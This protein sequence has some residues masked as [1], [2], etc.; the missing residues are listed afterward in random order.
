MAHSMT[1]VAAAAT[2]EAVTKYRRLHDGLSDMV[3]GG[4]LDESDIPDDYQWLVDSL[5]ELAAVDP[6]GRHD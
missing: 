2:E 1:S 6:A 3:E 5:A 4:R